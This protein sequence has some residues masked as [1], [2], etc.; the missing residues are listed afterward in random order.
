M[1]AIKCE[2]LN[3]QKTIKKKISPDYSKRNKCSEAT[4]C[5]IHKECDVKN[6]V[7]DTEQYTRTLPWH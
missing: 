6:T 7:I 1:L 4:L 3:D 2:V 5:L